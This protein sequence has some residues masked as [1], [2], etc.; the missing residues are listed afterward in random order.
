MEQTGLDTTQH[1]A[2][3][4]ACPGCA[5]GTVAG[6]KA[7]RLRPSARTPRTPSCRL[8]PAPVTGQGH[9]LSLCPPRHSSSLLVKTIYARTS[10][11]PFFSRPTRRAPSH[12]V[13]VRSSC[14]P[15]CVGNTSAVPRSSIAAGAAARTAC[16]LP[17][18]ALILVAGTIDHGTTQPAYVP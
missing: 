10:V 13:L 18:T 12:Y 15:Y 4:F 6:W 2:F 11:A 3:A 8:T 17:A 7:W 1:L 9:R 16:Q 5:V 14:S